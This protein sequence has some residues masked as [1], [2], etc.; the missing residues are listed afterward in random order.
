DALD[1][2]GHA[3]GG[4]AEVGGR[5]GEVDAS[6]GQSDPG[7]RLVLVARGGA[8]AG[9]GE[10][11]GAGQGAERGVGTEAQDQVAD[12]AGGQRLAVHADRVAGGRVGA[13]GQRR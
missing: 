7:Q 8:E 10:P 12:R 6:D 2:R 11:Q 4:G 13:R 5:G 9:G 3:R 1:G